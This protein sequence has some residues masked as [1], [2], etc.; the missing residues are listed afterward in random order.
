MSTL[1][2]IVNAEVAYANGT[3]LRAGTEIDKAWVGLGR[4]PN[5]KLQARL[6]KVDGK[7]ERNC[8]RKHP[9]RSR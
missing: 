2:H 5:K 3:C 7:F 6:E 4:K 1:K 9:K 8:V